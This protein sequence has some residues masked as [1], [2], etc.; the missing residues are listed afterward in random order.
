V[1]VTV[2]AALLAE[3]VPVPGV[4]GFFPPEPVVPRTAITH[5]NRQQEPKYL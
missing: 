4:V 2:A 5:S 1:K 3:A